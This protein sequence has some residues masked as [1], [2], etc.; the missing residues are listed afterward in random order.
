MRTQPDGVN[1]INGLTK[2]AAVGL[3]SGTQAPYRRTA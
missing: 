3:V 1:W 2:G